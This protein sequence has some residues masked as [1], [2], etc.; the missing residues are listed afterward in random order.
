MSD[1]VMRLL[2]RAALIWAYATDDQHNGPE[3]EKLV[4][5]KRYIALDLHAPHTP[6]DTSADGPSNRKASQ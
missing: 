1:V 5:P 6:V 2:L 3:L 4:Y